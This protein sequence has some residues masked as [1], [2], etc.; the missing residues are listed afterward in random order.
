MAFRKKQK[1]EK[2][3]IRST[4]GRFVP[5]EETS[6]LARIKIFISIVPHG[7]ADGVVKLLERVGVNYSVITQGEGTGAKFV[8]NLVADNKKQIIFSFVREDLTDKV[9]NTLKQRFSVS[10]ASN[11][12]SFSINLTSVMGVSIYKFLSNTRKVTG[13]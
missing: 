2:K 10:K 7:Q 8:P 11:G 4:N 9:K 12:I 5:Y 6:N 3:L 13:K 1:E